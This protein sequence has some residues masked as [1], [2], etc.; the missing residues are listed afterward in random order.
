MKN[1][2]E[3]RGS[4]TAIFVSYKGQILEALI[5][6][7]DL[8]KVEKYPNTWWAHWN[9]KTKSFYIHGELY[10][11]K[12]RKRIRLHRWIM[13]VPEGMTVDHK[14]H[15]TLDNRRSS[16]LRILTNSENLQNKKGAC[17]RSK[18]G[19]RCVWWNK[20][21]NKYEVRVG[22]NKKKYFIGYFDDINLAEKEAIKAIKK[23]LKYA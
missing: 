18:T 15:D 8:G 22:C 2:F 4:V 6:T 16:N 5:D 9:K 20:E 21:R 17:S 19:I 10:K 11:S 7:D 23:Y 14:N 1:S 13:D 12:S 3:I